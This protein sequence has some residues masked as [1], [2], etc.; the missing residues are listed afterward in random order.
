MDADFSH[1]PKYLP[2]LLSR[3]DD[4]EVVIASRYVAGGGVTGWSLK[5]KLMSRSINA[6]ARLMLGL[7]T[8]DNSGSF[9]CYCVAKLR[10]LPLDGIR[11]TGYAIQEELLYHCQ[12]ARCRFVEVPFTF[13]ERRHGVSKINWR[14]AF[15]ALWV[16]FR[17]GC[18]GEHPPG[19][20][21]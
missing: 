10:E 12:R 3:A 21:D 9:R 11:A 4:A 19:R 7:T 17:L 16:L 5:R 6:Y 14:E 18:C 2:E 13:E 15:S 1:P 20:R 8:R